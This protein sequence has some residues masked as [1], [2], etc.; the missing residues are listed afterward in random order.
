MDEFYSL[1]TGHA[2]AFFRMCM[3]L[4][5]VIEEVVNRS[6]ASTIPNDTVIAE[7]QTIA[8][9][10]KGSFALALYMLGFGSYQGFFNI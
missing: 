2:D 5:N 7:L 9:N 6:A 1:V 10:E 8:D 3:A 4:P